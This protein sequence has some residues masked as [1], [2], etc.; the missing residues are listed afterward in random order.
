MIRAL[1]LLTPSS[2]IVFPLKTV[3]SPSFK[4]YCILKTDEKDTNDKKKNMK[5]LNKT[6][7]FIIPPNYNLISELLSII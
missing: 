1:E 6:D 7:F 5:R 3:D 4:R 2:L